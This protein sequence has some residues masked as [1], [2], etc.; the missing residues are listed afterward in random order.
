MIQS[1]WAITAWWCSMLEGCVPG[2]YYW[3]VMTSD[4][5]E[6]FNAIVPPTVDDVRALLRPN[7]TGIPEVLAK[8]PAGEGPLADVPLLDP[9]EIAP[10]RFEELAGTVRVAATASET[11]T[12]AGLL[13]VPGGGLLV[14]AIVLGPADLST[15]PNPA[16]SR[17]ALVRAGAASDQV[18]VEVVALISQVEDGGGPAAGVGVVRPLVLADPA[19]FP[20]EGD[21]TPYGAALVAAARAAVAED[22]EVVADLAGRPLDPLDGHVARVWSPLFEVARAAT[23]GLAARSATR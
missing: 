23:V 22:R 13:D 17:A 5:L 19:S 9:A 21:D 14:T 11:A 4:P 15:P 8:W 2:R 12:V 16:A 3:S 20:P 18:L 10:K 1:A 7:M 6:H